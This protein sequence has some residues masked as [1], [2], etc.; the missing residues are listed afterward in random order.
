MTSSATAS[1]L[2]LLWR[3]GFLNLTL[4]RLRI[5]NTL[6]RNITRIWSVRGVNIEKLWPRCLLELG[7]RKK[8]ERKT[9]WKDILIAY[10]KAMNHRKCYEMRYSDMEL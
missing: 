6:W 7:T 10:M 3:L 2:R 8:R 5:G 1:T 4:F 9:E